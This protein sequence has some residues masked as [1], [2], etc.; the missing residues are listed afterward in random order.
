MWCRKEIGVW[1]SS[2]HA[3]RSFYLCTLEGSNNHRR[4]EH[5]MKANSVTFVGH[6]DQVLYTQNKMPKLCCL[7]KPTES[8]ECACTWI[9]LFPGAPKN[10]KTYTMWHLDLVIN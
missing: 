10:K 9:S 7:A 8:W 5:G 4:K 1:K 2:F 6:K 3:C